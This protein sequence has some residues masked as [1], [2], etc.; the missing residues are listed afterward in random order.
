MKKKF[1]IF[2][3]FSSMSFTLCFVNSANK[4]VRTL[5]TSGSGF[6]CCLACREYLKKNR[7]RSE[8]NHGV[9]TILD[10]GLPI[11]ENSVLKSASI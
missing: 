9:V 2:V 11:V 4:P 7:G 1:S 8:Q 10:A 6:R 5:N 3:H